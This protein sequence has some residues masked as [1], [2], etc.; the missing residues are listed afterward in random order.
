MILVQPAAENMEDYIAIIKRENLWIEILDLSFPEVMDN[1]ELYTYSK[2]YP[3]HRC[4]TL[5]GAFMDINIASRDQEIR[6]IS[7]ERCRQSCEI[8]KIFGIR[9]VIFSTGLYTDRNIYDWIV[10]NAAFFRGLAIEF[11]LQIY[12][13]NFMDR[14][15]EPLYRLLETAGEPRLKACLD[16]GRITH[17]QFPAEAWVKLLRKHIGYIHLSERNH[18][19]GSRLAF[20][21]GRND[22]ER[23]SKLCKLLACEVKDLPVTILAGS[24]HQLERSLRFLKDHLY[25]PCASFSR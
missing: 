23:I 1:R 22:W 16:F 24:P 4:R 14:S 17:T 15:P 8:A 18:L 5:Y 12:L 13:K 11:D 21:D 3:P 6:R 19:F 7:Q 10:L 9:Q 2:K 25:F 20:G